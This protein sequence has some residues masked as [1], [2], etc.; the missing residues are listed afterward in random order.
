MTSPVVTLGA[1]S[2][3]QLLTL[4]NAQHQQRAVAVAQQYGITDR[5]DL[6]RLRMAVDAEAMVRL[7]QQISTHRG[8]QQ[9]RSIQK[10]AGANL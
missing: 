8:G 1:L 7:A 10:E 4:I 9:C 3:D 5:H 6:K 2:G